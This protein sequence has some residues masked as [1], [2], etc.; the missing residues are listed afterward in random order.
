MLSVACIEV[1]RVS[2]TESN[3]PRVLAQRA[4]NDI[5]MQRPTCIEACAIV[6]H[7]PEEWPLQISAMSCHIEIVFD[8]L[9]DLGVNGQTPLLAAFA[10]DLQ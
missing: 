7:W 6:A 2:P 4:I 9:Y 5:R 3:V 10:D 1:G 8:A